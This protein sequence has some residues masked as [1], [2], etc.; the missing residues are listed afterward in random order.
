[1]KHL[2]YITRFLLTCILFPVFSIAFAGKS[3]LPTSF[4]PGKIINPVVCDADA[5]QTY[6]VYIPARGNKAALPVIYMFDPHADGALPLTKYKHL[7]DE[8]G[9][10][11][12]GSNNSKNG[13]DWQTTGSIW[14][15]L[16]AD[17]QKKLKI[18][19]NRIYT[20][21]FSGG[22]KVAGYVAIEYPAVKGVIANG[23]GLPDG[24]EAG[25]FGFSF[26]GVAGE[27]DM[28]M[29]V[30]LNF[31]NSL[32]NTAT[33]HRMLLF[34]G[35][36]EWA[37][38]ATINIAF[39]GLEFDGMRQGLLPKNDS[40]ISL[41][42][43]Q[44]RQRITS[45]SQS[46]QLIKAKEEC[47]IAASFLTGL[48][49]ESTWFDQQA[50]AIRAKPLYQNQLKQQQALL[51]KEQQLE[52][53]YMQQ[54]QQGSM[55]YWTTTISG[56]QKQ[57]AAKTIESPMYQRLLAWLS[58]AFYSV[59]NQLI[60][61]NQN[62]AA[63]HFVD[64]YKIADPTNSEAWYFSAILNARSA[65]PQSAQSDLLK[66]ASCGFNDK[67][68]LEQQPEFKQLKLN[69]AVVENKMMK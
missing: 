64:L 18:N 2:N 30:L 14:K 36:H 43:T 31:C 37:P 68:R 9:F 69:L 8:Y 33:R 7:A 56:L 65:M 28:N 4:Q 29:A 40:L 41:Y 57:A 50:G 61:S 27:G 47:D 19:G 67:G 66:A 35:K 10:I 24:V 51:N 52:A 25:N 3:P 1:M 34:N 26:T 5:S 62:A 63:R 53:G 45:L 49:N 39:M 15:K 60:N 13:N 38:A 12:V 54:F 44:S 21:G 59:S 23:A 32:D 55:D 42:I 11:L 20:C 46:K 6:A 48:S 58:L 22:A 16:F 17:T